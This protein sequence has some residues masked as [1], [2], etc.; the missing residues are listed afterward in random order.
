[1][2]VDGARWVRQNVLA[3]NPD[4]PL[5]VYAIWFDAYEG[6][7]RSRVDTSLLDDPRVTQFWDDRK[8]AGW[9]YARTFTRPDD[10]EWIEWDAFFVYPPGATWDDSGA[11]PDAWGRTIVGKHD[12]LRDAVAKLIDK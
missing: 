4:A 9:W 1:M 8:E 11:R 2:C 10:P 6:D 12:A 7:E 5:C 3:A